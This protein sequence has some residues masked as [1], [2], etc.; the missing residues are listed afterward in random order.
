[1][2][3]KVFLG[4]LILLFITGCENKEKDIVGFFPSGEVK[5][6][7]SIK[8]GKRNGTWVYYDKKGDTT[9]LFHYNN[10]SLFLRETYIKGNL[11]IVEELRDSI[12]NGKTIMYYHNGKVKS[13]STFK[14]GKEDGI[15]KEY[16]PN[17]V[18]RVSGINK[19]S[20]TVDFEQYYPNG[21]LFAKADT[22]DYGLVSFY[23]SLGNKSV[24]VKYYKNGGRDTIKVY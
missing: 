9:G 12:P 19:G 6:R 8:E 20:L 3:N 2:S 14:D 4:F 5:Y 23:D 7:G 22:F 21:K 24:D 18:I 13:M 11:A 10:G 16:F 17:G 15:F 1:M